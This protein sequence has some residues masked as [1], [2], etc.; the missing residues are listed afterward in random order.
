ME[1][2]HSQFHHSS[3]KKKLITEKATLN[4]LHKRF[5]FEL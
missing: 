4:F 1:E 3:E 2:Q 5:L